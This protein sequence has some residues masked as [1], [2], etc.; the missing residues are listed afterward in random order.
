MNNLS[1]ALAVALMAATVPATIVLAQQA[2]GEQPNAEQSK[3]Q[4]G[5]SAETI[6][7]L[8]DGRIAMAKAALKLTPEQE[9]LWAPVEEKIRAR[10]EERRKAREAWQAKAD[11]RRA[12]RK[13]NAEDG[14]RE[15]KALPERIE[16]R[17]ERM[18]KMAERLTERAAKSKE[19]AETLKP[20]YASFSDEQK[21]VAGKVLGHFAGGKRGHGHRQGWAMHRGFGKGHG[22]HGAGPQ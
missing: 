20:L 9:K 1:R 21:A 10:F 8:E 14:K 17:S 16:E 4:R 19:F 7:R 5:P 22:G 12:E 11:E 13:A 3:K 18:S 15:R 2:P 6:S